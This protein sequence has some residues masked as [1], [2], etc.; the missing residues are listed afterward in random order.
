MEIIIYK[1]PSFGMDVAFYTFN[2]FGGYRNVIELFLENKFISYE[3]NFSMTFELS[4]I[5]VRT[6]REIAS[7]K[8]F[9]D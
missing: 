4:C 3:N 8:E 9:F 7:F 6:T 1:S 5:S 2:R